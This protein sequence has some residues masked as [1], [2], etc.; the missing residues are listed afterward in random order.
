MN[1]IDTLVYISLGISQAEAE[2]EGV[3]LV[4]GNFGS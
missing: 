3:L 2:P 4:L 1:L